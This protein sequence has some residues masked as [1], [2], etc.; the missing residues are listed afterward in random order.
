MNIFRLGDMFG[1]SGSEM[2]KARKTVDQTKV[3]SYA[4][5]LLSA[6]VNA[7]AFEEALVALDSDSSLGAA[8]LIALAF[9]YNRGGKKPRSR[10]AALTMIRKRYVEIVRTDAKNRIAEKARPW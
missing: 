9:A 10:A 8:D 2:A 7:A 6:G 3:A 1:Q 4:A 5:R